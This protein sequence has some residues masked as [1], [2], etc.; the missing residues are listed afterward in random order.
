[1]PSRRASPRHSGLVSLGL[2]LRAGPYRRIPHRSPAPG[3]GEGASGAGE[4]LEIGRHGPP[5]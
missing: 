3:A 1:M 5:V 4:R 2:R